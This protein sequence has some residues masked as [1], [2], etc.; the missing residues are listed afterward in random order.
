MSQIKRTTSENLLDVRKVNYGM[1]RGHSLSIYGHSLGKKRTSL[2]M[3]REKSNHYYIQTRHN[4]LFF[5]LQSF[6]RK[7]WRKMGPKSAHRYWASTSDRA[8]IPWAS[9]NTPK[10]YL[11]QYCCRID[12]KV[13]LENCWTLSNS[14][15][16]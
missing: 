2:C 16:H 6:S 4:D 13:F 12:K 1:P 8:H 3:A 10:I 7:T 15:E 11:I 5:S 9:Y 14:S